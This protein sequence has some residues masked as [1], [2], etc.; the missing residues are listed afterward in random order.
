MINF[1]SI[2]KYIYLNRYKRFTYSELS[3]FYF[4]LL[5]YSLGLYK[6]YT[7][8][9]KESVY[10]TL[11]IFFMNTISLLQRDDFIFFKKQLGIFKTLIIMYIDVLLINIPLLFLTVTKSISFLV[12]EI[13]LIFTLPLFL[14]LRK[15]RFTAIPLFSS[16]DPLWLS[17]IRKKPWSLAFLII[18]YYVQYQGLIVDNI[19]LFNVA[20]FGVLFFISNI[21]SE[22]EHLIYFKLSDKKI[23]KHLM[24][25]LWIN[26]KNYIV[27]LIPSILSVLIL[28][29]NHIIDLIPVV[30]GGSLVFWLRYFFYNNEFLR[31]LSSVFTIIFIIV[32]F[33]TINIGLYFLIIILLNV[34][35]A[36]LTF[37][38]LT[39]F[40]NE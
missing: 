1:L 26:L 40:L 12:I 11:V 38:R 16:K 34:I 18:L 24:D 39:K 30:I 25:M 8:E 3:P 22:K 29:F 10:V 13:G 32:I 37:K 15:V 28:A 19:G 21:F 6:I 17:Y 5:I 14:L 31:T 27:V 7:W 2:I 33:S 20:S 4:F 36:K 23:E 35:L 9:S